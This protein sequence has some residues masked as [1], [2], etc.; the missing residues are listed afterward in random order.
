MM[1]VKDVEIQNIVG[2]MK[3]YVIKKWRFRGQN[4]LFGMILI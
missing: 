3:G 2:E 4:I 1:V